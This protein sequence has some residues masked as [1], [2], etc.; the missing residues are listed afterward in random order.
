MGELVDQAWSPSLH[1]L[2]QGF[3]VQSPAYIHPSLEDLG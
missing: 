1:G 2:V 3:S